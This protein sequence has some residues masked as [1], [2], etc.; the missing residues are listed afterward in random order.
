[1]NIIVIY[2][3]TDTCK[4][5]LGWKRIADGDEGGS[6]K[7]WAELPPPSNLAVQLGLVKPIEC[8]RCQGTGVEPKTS[9][10]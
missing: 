10:S 4:E 9:S 3:G 7:H 1:M 8:P 6:W 5:C 2:E